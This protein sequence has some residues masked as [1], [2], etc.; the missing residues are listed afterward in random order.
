M[1]KKIDPEEVLW[2]KY[3]YPVELSG[4]RFITESLFHQ[5][6]VNGDLYTREMVEKIKEEEWN[7]GWEDANYHSS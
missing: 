2:K 3:A 4:E 5:M 1:D 6:F 7:K